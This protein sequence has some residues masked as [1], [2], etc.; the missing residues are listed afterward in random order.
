MPNNKR[1]YQIYCVNYD[2]FWDN[3]SLFNSTLNLPDIKELYPIR[4]ETS[5]HHSIYRKE[6]TQIYKPLNDKME[7][8]PPIVV[9]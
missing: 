3:I 4:K 9:V 2:K 7:L 6:L 8:F 5:T 1:N